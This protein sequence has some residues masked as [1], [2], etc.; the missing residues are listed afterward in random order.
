[1]STELELLRRA[2]ALM[3][4]EAENA[5]YAPGRWA[6]DVAGPLAST[7]WLGPSHDALTATVRQAAHVHSFGNPAVALAVAD[8]LD[9]CVGIWAG[10]AQHMMKVATTHGA[11]EVALA[12]LGEVRDD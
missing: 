3:R 5:Q 12:Y 8:W 6:V 11:L 7:A 2:A 9:T 4:R 10:D 1:M